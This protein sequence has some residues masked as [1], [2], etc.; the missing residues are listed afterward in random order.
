MNKI[1]KFSYKVLNYFNINHHG[2]DSVENNLDEIYK[3]NCIQLIY[4]I[5]K[6][7][8]NTNKDV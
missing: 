7:G 1:K 2:S 5:D 3:K 6:G 8:N 4:V